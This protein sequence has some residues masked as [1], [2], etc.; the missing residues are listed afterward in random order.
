MSSTYHSRFHDLHDVDI[1]ENKIYGDLDLIITH[2][3]LSKI[4]DVEKSKFC[5]YMPE[6]A[7]RYYD[8]FY[9]PGVMTELKEDKRDPR[10]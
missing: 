1:P 7:D 5:R 6:F 4:G 2:P 9:S 10:D 3:V 8:F